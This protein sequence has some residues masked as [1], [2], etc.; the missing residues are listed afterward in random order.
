MHFHF[1]CNNVGEQTV[2][3]GPYVIFAFPPATVSEIV[4]AVPCAQ[5]VSLDAICI[6]RYIALSNFYT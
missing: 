1:A 6:R 4:I 3:R 2:K 5:E